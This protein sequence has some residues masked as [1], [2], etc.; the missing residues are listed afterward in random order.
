MIKPLEILQREIM[1][2][3]EKLGQQH[4]WLDTLDT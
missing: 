3:E 4:G 2:S 1:V